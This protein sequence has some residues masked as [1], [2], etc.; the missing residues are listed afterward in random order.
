MDS[1][2]SLFDPSDGAQKTAKRK[3]EQDKVKKKGDAPKGR[4]RGRRSQG[5][6]ETLPEESSFLCEPQLSTELLVKDGSYIEIY[7]EM[8][9]DSESKADA[10]KKP[11]RRNSGRKN[12]RKKKISPAK[13]LTPNTAWHQEA[14]VPETSWNNQNHLQKKYEE[15]AKNNNEN[16]GKNVNDLKNIKTSK[17]KQFENFKPFEDREVYNVID[18]LE[19]VSLKDDMYLAGDFNTDELEND[20]IYSSDDMDE[21]F[22]DT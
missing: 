10:E 19:K 15:I 4:R 21:S 12:R 1:F 7:I 17:R 2:L 13:D 18:K 20:F 3:P 5:K 22:D 9:R 16:I 11:K 14:D 8:K 6:S